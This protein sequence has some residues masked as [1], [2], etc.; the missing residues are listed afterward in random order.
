[1][2]AGWRNALNL[3]I[4]VIRKRSGMWS[5]RCTCDQSSALWMHI[6]SLHNDAAPLIVCPV[7][8]SR[9]FFYLFQTAVWLQYISFDDAEDAVK[10]KPS[11]C[12]IALHCMLPVLLKV[13]D[14]VWHDFQKSNPVTFRFLPV[15]CTVMLKLLL[16]GGQCVQLYF[17]IIILSK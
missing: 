16:P 1:M 10:C 2:K 17:Q 9:N 5:G 7:V 14:K 8:F 12:C 13:H 3:R 4:S 11:E 6:I 15:T